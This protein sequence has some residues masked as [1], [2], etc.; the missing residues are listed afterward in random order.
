MNIL[1]FIQ[2]AK[3][4]NPQQMMINMLEQ[5]A[6]ASSNNNPIALNLLQCA[7]KGDTKAIEAIA[8]NI[9]NEKGVSFDEAFNSFRNQW[10]L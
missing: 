9:C 6:N 8:R 3:K 7:K 2:M 4:G 10:G 5:Q 1:Q